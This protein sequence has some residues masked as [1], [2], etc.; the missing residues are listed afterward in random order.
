MIKER[1]AIAAN[2]MS[3]SLENIAVNCKEDESIQNT[4]DDIDRLLE[5]LEE[6]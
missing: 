3:E 4:L 6:A 2:M 1:H 5:G